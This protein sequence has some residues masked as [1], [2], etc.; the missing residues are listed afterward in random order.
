VNS[1][2]DLIAQPWVGMSWE[3]WVIEQILA[4]LNNRG[5]SCASF[6]FRTS[7]GCEL[8]L[9]LRIKGELWAFEIKLTTSPG[10]REN[11]LDLLRFSRLQS[12]LP[13]HG[14]KR[15]FMVP[16]G[17]LMTENDMSWKPLTN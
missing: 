16:R 6:F 13:G 7:D 9:V 12:P 5:V 8:D 1:A 4:A 14:G 10:K 3:G 17:Q 11:G 15:P 2:T